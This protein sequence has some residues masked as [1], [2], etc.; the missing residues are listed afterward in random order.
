MKSP[1]PRT[2]SGTPSP[3]LR[4]PASSAPV[5]RFPALAT[6]LAAGVTLPACHDP[7]CGATR[8]DELESHGRNLAPALRRG[9]AGVALREIA[10]ALGLTAHAATRIATPDPTR[11]AAPGESPVV[12]T[13]PPEPVPPLTPTP[14][15]VDGGVRSVTPTPPPP[16]PPAN[17][18]PH[19]TTS[20]GARRGRIR[21]VSPRPAPRAAGDVSAVTAFPTDRRG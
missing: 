18:R 20:P 11:V 13:T 2:L 1:P 17:P 19:P 7:A 8:A 6:V 9:E 5:A 15:G 16:P 14:I 12:T 21:A 4:V 3:Q 10:V